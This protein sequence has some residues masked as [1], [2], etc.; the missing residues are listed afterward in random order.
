MA[1]A[2]IA[3]SRSE[4]QCLQLKNWLHSLDITGVLVEDEDDL[5]LSVLEKFEHYARQCDVAFVVLTPEDGAAGSGPDVEQ[6]AG[7]NTLIE[8]GWLLRHCGR[9]RVLIM[10]QSGTRLPSGIEGMLR[11][12]FTTSIL[13][14]TEQIRRRLKGLGLL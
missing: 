7:P 13:E 9:Q 6:T 2:F 3:H 1:T 8:L 12:T 11:L 4:L 14:C 5:G 10:Q